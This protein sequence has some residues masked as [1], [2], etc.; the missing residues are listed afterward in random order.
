MKNFS[1]TTLALL[2][3]LLL[4]VSASPTLRAQNSP[5]VEL[6]PITLFF[7]F[8]VTGISGLTSDPKPRSVSENGE[9]TGIGNPET[10][11][12]DNRVI[13]ETGRP[14]V[15]EETTGDRAFFVKQVFQRA[16]DNIAIQSAE[17]N[18]AA[19]TRRLEARLLEDAK[20][21][22]ANWEISGVRLPQTTVAG[23][24]STPYRLFLTLTDQ[25][26]SAG[27][28]VLDTGITLELRS[29][30]FNGTETT[31]P[32]SQTVTAASGKFTAQMIFSFRG[33]T[34]S[35]PLYKLTL[36][37]RRAALS[38]TSDTD[39]SSI[40]GAEWFIFAGGHASGQIRAF[41]GTPTAISLSKTRATGHGSWYKIIT[42]EDNEGNAIVD[43][44][45]FA[46]IT[47]FKITFGET[48]Y[49]DSRLYLGVQ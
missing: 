44:D 36:E 5:F 14:I 3:G 20:L 38:G 25:A 8:T 16:L 11:P 15:F 29:Y 4:S 24:L 12:S 19:T 2:G 33:F 23:A 26:K 42:K 7:D 47:P 49:V 43:F 27:T 45:S 34:L 32:N 6:L 28:R 22:S 40:N 37:D 10:L 30:M 48:K 35:S 18:D 13:T 17:S 9:I 31:A 39:V 21:E 46:G 1:R 41:P